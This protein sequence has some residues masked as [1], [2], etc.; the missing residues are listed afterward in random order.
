MSN[1]TVGFLGFCDDAGHF[2]LDDRAAFLAY[3]KKKFA[4]QEVVLS[5]KKRPTRQG[6]QQLRYLRGVVIP[7]IAEACGY[8]PEDPDECQ[9]VYEG[10]MWKLFRLEDGPFGEP[11]REHCDKDSMSQERLT[12]VIDTILRWAET[13]ITGCTIRRPEDVDDAAERRHVQEVGA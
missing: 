11:R 8:N 13:T 12:E 2:A 7:D 3:V 5:V 6:N 10:I 4:G 1:Q 9:A